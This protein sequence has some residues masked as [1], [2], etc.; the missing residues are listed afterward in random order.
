MTVTELSVMVA[1]IFNNLGTGIV[2]VIRIRKLNKIS[3]V[4]STL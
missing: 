4:Y 1:A 2:K 3:N